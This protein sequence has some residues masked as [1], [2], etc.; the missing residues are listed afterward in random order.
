MEET[1]KTVASLNAALAEAREGLRKADAILAD[2]QKIAASTRE[3]TTD[4]GTLRQEVE[5]SLRRVN[6][7]IDEINRKWPFARDTEVKLP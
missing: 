1:R 6:S 5:S 4:L 2:A 7:L 3:A